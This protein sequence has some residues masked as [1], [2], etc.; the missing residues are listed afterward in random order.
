[1]EVQKPSPSSAVDARS[2]AGHFRLFRYS[3]ARYG[4][5]GRLELSG[6]AVEGAQTRSKT[7]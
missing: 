5:S 3:L 4:K 7:G 1:M 2:S 6:W